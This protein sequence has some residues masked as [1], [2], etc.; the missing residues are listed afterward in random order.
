MNIKF[1]TIRTY[2]ENEKTDSNNIAHLFS[3]DKKIVTNTIDDCIADGYLKKENQ[4]IVITE[5]GK[6]YVSQ[7]KVDKAIILACGK[8]TRLEPITF[9]MPKSFLRVKG[10]RMIERQIEQLKSAGIDDITI[11]IGYMKESFYYLKDKYKVKLIYNEEYDTKNTLAT[12]YKA[13]DIIKNNNVYICVSDV[14]M[15]DNIYHKYE[16]ENYYCGAFAENLDKEWQYVRDENNKITGVLDGGVNEYFMV[17]PSFM[18]KEFIDRLLPLIEKA[19]NEK[20][21]EGYYWENVL[22][23]NFKNLPDMYLY[24][25]PNDTIYEFDKLEDLKEFDKNIDTG[26]FSFSFVAD[27][28]KVREKDIKNIN[29]IKSGITNKS[30]IFSIDD[31][32]KYICRVP[33]LGT[34]YFIDR[35]TEKEVYEKLKNKNITEEIIA[36]DIDGVK[37]S[38]YFENAIAVDEHNEDDMR[39][40]MKLYRKLHNSGVQVEKSSDIVDEIKRYQNII[41]AHEVSSNKNV[42]ANCVSDKNKSCSRSSQQQKDLV[43]N[44][45]HCSRELCERQDDILEELIKVKNRF[46]RPKTL[47]HGDANPG[48]VLKTNDGLKL[49]DFEYSGMGDPLMDIALFSVYVGFSIDEAMKL[50]SYYNEDEDSENILMTNID[51]NDVKILLKCYMALSC[52]WGVVWQV[53]KKELDGKGSEEYGEKMQKLLY[54]LIS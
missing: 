52:Y 36:F 12:L 40:T 5:K 44:L 22:V 42:V 31:N 38:K 51:M 18:T 10:D 2:L 7:Y 47:I 14:Y 23:E 49:I 16:C 17:G 37:I 3:V 25:I 1:L 28:F 48:N 21:T 24:K 6:N 15:V 30:Y 29:C 53:L 9:D 8:G 34:N 50:V 45:S 32:E 20:G 19:Y 39:E 11:M 35:K 41:A 33:G 27:T 13:K 43:T 46:N 26:S 54:E 4:N